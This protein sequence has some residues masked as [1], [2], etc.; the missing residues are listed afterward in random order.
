MA[1]LISMVGCASLFGIHDPVAAGGD[2]G[3]DGRDGDAPDA[4]L[5]APSDG[6]TV[7]GAPLLLSEVVLAP[8]DGELIEIVNTSGQAVDLSSFFV[9]DSGSYFRLPGG[10]PV[11]DGGDFIAKFPAGA[12]VPAHGIVTIALA[13]EADFVTNYGIAPTFSIAS[14]TMAVVAVNGVPS[15]TSG[16]EVIVLFFWDGNSDL[17]SDGDILLAGSP[18]AGNSLIDKSGILLDGP[19]ADAQTSAYAIDANTLTIQAG[20]PGPSRSTKRIGIEVGHETQEGVGNG[21][22]GHDET[23]ESSAATWDSVAFSIPTPGAVPP[24]LLP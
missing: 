2:G 9:T 23:T 19:D 3:A 18:S 21:L 22:D 11:L 10:V 12:S 20:T 17:V 4:G 13:T 5:D 6:G 8:S 24:A 14:A 15:L 1:A 7:S 16:G